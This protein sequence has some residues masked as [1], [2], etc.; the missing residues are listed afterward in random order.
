MRPLPR[1][2]IRAWLPAAVMSLVA[3]GQLRASYLGV[4]APWRGGGFAM[5]SSIDQTDKRTLSVT[6]TDGRG[7]AHR[8]RVAGGELDRRSLPARTWPT[9]ARLTELAD[10]LIAQRWLAPERPSEA[11]QGQAL[12]AAELTGLQ[13]AGSLRTV[14]A[15]C[16]DLEVRGPV[17]RQPHQVGSRS[18]A[19]VRRCLR[20]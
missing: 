18:L 12:R 13:L 4:L 8:A 2:A 10:W 1:M 11:G 17:Y 14:A 19:S 16:I 20:P 3:A 5:F 7:K 6:L 15:T 9:P